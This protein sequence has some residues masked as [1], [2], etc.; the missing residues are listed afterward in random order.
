MISQTLE[1][2]L[3]AVVHL[4]YEAPRPRTTEQIAAATRVPPAYLSKVLQALNR[5]G[6]V[7]SQRGSKGGIC[8]ADAPDQ[9]TLLTIVNAV[10]PIPRILRCPLELVAHGVQLCALHRRLDAAAGLVESAFARTTLAE[11][12]SDSRDDVPYCEFPTARHS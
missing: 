5:G 10:E 7:R 9:L 8:L 2:A 3:R 12:I 11:I 6:I 4:A 1:Y